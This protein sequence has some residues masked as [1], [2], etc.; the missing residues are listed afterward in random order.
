MSNIDEIKPLIDA[1]DFIKFTDRSIGNKFTA[2]LKALQ[3]DLQ[4]AEGGPYEPSTEAEQALNELA[5]EIADALEKLEEEEEIK[6]VVV[7]ATKEEEEEKIIDEVLKAEDEDEDELE[8]LSEAA[9]DE[10]LDDD[11]LD[12]E[13]IEVVKDP[14]K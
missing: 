6:E 14:E 10:T 2:A 3:I 8:D 5:V 4:E 11:I 12:N 7:E 13:R 9:E 1:L